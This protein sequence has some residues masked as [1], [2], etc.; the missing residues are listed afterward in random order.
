MRRKR[1]RISK[2][3]G[4]RISPSSSDRKE[5]PGVFSGGCGNGILHA[6]LLCRTHNDEATLQES[7]RI[8][9]E[10]RPDPSM[11]ARFWWHGVCAEIHGR[12]G[13][14]QEAIQ[15]MRISLDNSSP[16]DFG[17]RHYCEDRLSRLHQEA[18]Q[19]EEAENVLRKALDDNKERLGDDHVITGYA[20]TDLAELLVELKKCTEA[21]EL[22]QQARPVSYP[23]RM[24]HQARNS[25]S[26]DC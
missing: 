6:E 14:K 17:V 15:Q 3:Y 24:F 13:N 11:F 18:E 1:K 2:R 12:L 26:S 10:T 20:R 9:K 19:F 23:R 22:L 4:W 21:E 5:G 16:E 25:E 8:L 7:L